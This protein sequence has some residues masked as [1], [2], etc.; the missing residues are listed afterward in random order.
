MPAAAKTLTRLAIATGMVLAV[1]GMSP[2]QAVLPAAPDVAPDSEC[3]EPTSDGHARA[4]GIEREPE[5]M[6]ISAAE[7]ARIERQIDRRVER[8][9]AT[10]AAA[11]EV[12]VYT[13]VMLDKQGNGDVTQQQ[14]DDQI[15]VLNT[16]FGGG[17][18]PEAADT[19]FTFTLAGVDRYHN[20][21]WHR[22]RASKRYRS[23]TRQ[24]GADALNMWLVDFDY[25]G[26]AT[27]PWSY[28][29]QSKVDGIRVHYDSLPGGGIDNYNLGGTAT[30]EAGHWLGLYHTFQGGCSE[31]GDEVDDTPAQA[32]PTSGCPEG[33]DSCAAPGL[34]PIHNY[35][36]YSYDRCYNQFTPGQAQRMSEAWTAYRG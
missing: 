11:V 28:V 31:P 12:P 9:A 35:M 32:S 6:H 19:G 20:N 24:G 3:V 25:L 7:Q 14:I 2:A 34:D 5:A 30:H 17:E 33:R 15:A 18:S 16:T 13:H 10:S 21:T 26:V 22:D 29:K 36:D 8:R 27:F 23:L 4:A 1:G